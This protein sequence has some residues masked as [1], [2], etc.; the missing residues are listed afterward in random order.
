MSPHFVCRKKLRPVAGLDIEQGSR[1]DP[2]R[3]LYEEGLRLDPERFWREDADAPSTAK[4]YRLRH[5][6]P[7]PSALNRFN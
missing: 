2:D 4:R 3:T 1:T 5:M 6:D 7:L